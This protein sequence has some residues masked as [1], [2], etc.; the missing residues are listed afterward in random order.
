MPSRYAIGDLNHS[1]VLNLRVRYGCVWWMPRTT[2]DCQC[3][4]CECRE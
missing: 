3:K 1:Q 2:R 4:Q